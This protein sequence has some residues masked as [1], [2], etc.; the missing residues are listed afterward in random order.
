METQKIYNVAERR[1]KRRKLGERCSRLLLVGK[2]D[3][4]KLLIS[5]GN[6]VVMMM[7]RQIV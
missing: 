2:S 3:I 4:E 1:I 7:S 6:E 5:F